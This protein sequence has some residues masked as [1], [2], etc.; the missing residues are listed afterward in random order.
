MGRYRRNSP[1][2]ELYTHSSEAMLGV[3]SVH[4]MLKLLSHDQ[5]RPQP[6]F[7]YREL[8]G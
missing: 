6:P 7:K 3:S 8:T 4:R 5:M 2:Y 1:D